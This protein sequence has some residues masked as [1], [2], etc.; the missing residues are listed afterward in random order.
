MKTRNYTPE[1]KERAVRMLIE[2]K[3]DYPSPG[4]PSKL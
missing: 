1:M 3:D 2:A 4:Q